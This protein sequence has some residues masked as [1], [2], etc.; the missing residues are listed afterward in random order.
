MSRDLYSAEAEHGV[1]GAIFITA[2]QGDQSLVDQIVEKLT[3]ADFYFDDNAALFQTMAELLAAGQPVDPVTVALERPTLPGGGKTLEY[4]F[5]IHRNVGS[6]ANWKAYCRHLRERATLRRQVEIGRVIQQLAEEDRPL[7]EIIAKAQEAMAD[8]RDLDEDVPAYRRLDEVV[9]KVCEKLQDE[10]DDRLPKFQ[11]TG[12]ADLDK[13]MRGLRPKNLTVVSGLPG[14]GKTML[15][16]QIAQYNAVKCKKPWLVFS[17]EM[18]EEPLGIRAIASL[19]GIDLKRLDEPK[20][21]ECDDWDR[22]TAAAAQSSGAPL[23]ICDDPTLTAARIRTVARHCKR[24]EGLAG[25]VV[26]YLGLIPADAKGRTRSEEVGA[27]CKALLRLAKELDVPMLLI[28]QLNRDSTKR[29][30]KD[31]RPRASDLRDS[32]EIEADASCIL[33]VHRDLDSEEGQNGITEILMPKNRYAQTGMCIVQQQGQY[34]RFV[35]LYGF[36]DPSH[37]EVEMG[38]SFASQYGGKGKA[39]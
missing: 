37:E 21:M 11:D 26:D 12:L 4:A 22:V 1:L 8:L 19:G 28:S 29:P 7:S 34:G 36:R 27:T 9:L 20:T 33:I 3:T 24:H 10:L 30:G 32:G 6:T 31:K 38:R 23:F 15:A 5:E 2:A 18:P 25:I 35:N 17:L 14:G 39:A 13:L 16:L